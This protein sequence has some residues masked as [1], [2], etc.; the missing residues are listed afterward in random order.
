[1]VSPSNHKET[2]VFNECDGQT[3]SV[4]IVV[5]QCETEMAWITSSWLVFTPVLRGVPQVNVTFDVDSKDSE[6][7]STWSPLKSTAFSSFANVMGKPSQVYKR[8][9]GTARR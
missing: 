7:V 1:M 2:G 9:A 5:C 6:S 4:D 8:G 3:M